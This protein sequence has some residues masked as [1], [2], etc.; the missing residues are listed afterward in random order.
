MRRRGV[1]RDRILRARR[2]AIAVPL[3]LCVGVEAVVWLG[4]LYGGGP[5]LRIAV[6]QHGAFWPGLLG[7][8][9]P[10]YPLQPAAMFVTHSLLHSGPAHL[11]GNMAALL[12]LGPRVLRR[13]RAPGFAAVWI[14]AVLTGAA[15]F[16]ALAASFAPMVGASGA[17]FGLLGA[18][19]ALRWRRNGAWGPALAATAG[20]ALLNALTFAA[21]G[22][23]LAWQTHLGGYLGGAAAA[24][25]LDGR[26]RRGRRARRRDTD[27]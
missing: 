3:V 6:L 23:V 14:A 20:L 7:D 22:G 25:W 18:L 16:G 12:W 26:R 13:L 2:A 21:E 19:V 10:N 17:I 11:L 9:Q 27:A 4:D 8:W 1:R 15:A 24:L 5:R